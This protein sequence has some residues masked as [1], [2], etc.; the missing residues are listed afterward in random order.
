MSDNSGQILIAFTFPLQRHKL[1]AV[2]L[3]PKNITYI[4]HV[5]P[6]VS[7]DFLFDPGSLHSHHM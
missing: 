6:T 4:F 2:V 1:H 7:A 3:Q 5:V